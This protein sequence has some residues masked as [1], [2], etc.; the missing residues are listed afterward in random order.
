MAWVVIANLKGV[1]GDAAALEILAVT[2][3]YQGSLPDG[4]NMNSYN[5]IGQRGTWRIVPGW[6]YANAPWGSGPAPEAGILEVLPPDFDSTTAQHVTT[7]TYDSWRTIDVVNQVSGS[8]KS[9]VAH[10]ELSMLSASEAI[11][12][13]AKADGWAA[14]YDPTNPATRQVNPDTGNIQRILDGLGNHPDAIAN[15]N[16]T[17]VP[18]AFGQLWGY[19]DSSLKV[20]FPT[21]VAQPVTYIGV[22]KTD[23]AYS[24]NTR[25]FI[26]GDTAGG[27]HR[28]YLEPQTSRLVVSDNTTYMSSAGA[29]VTDRPVVLSASFNGGVNSTSVNGQFGLC[30]TNGQTG[31]PVKDVRFGVR[32]AGVLHYWQGTIGPIL[33]YMGEIPQDK[34]ARMSNLL[35]SLAG[36]QRDSPPVTEGARLFSMDA[37]GNEEFVQGDPDAILT[38]GILSMTKMIN[39]L[40]AR[41][42]LTSNALLDQV[43]TL[44][45]GDF[46]TAFSTPLE[47]GDQITYRDLL[48]L[49][50]LP[51]DNSAPVALARHIGMDYITGDKSPRQ[52]Y[53][54]AMN[55]IL[56]QDLGFT[57]A[58]VMYEG[59]TAFLSPRQVAAVL[60]KLSEDP[61][62][63]E[64]FGKF[65]YTVTI[66]GANARTFGITSTLD[67]VNWPILGYVCG[68]SGT[69]GGNY[70]AAAMWKD[71]NGADHFTVA[72]DIPFGESVNAR[73]RDIRVA[74]D[75][76]LSG[77]KHLSREAHASTGTPIQTTLLRDISKLV[78]G[79]ESGVYLQRIGTTVELNFQNVVL[80]ESQWSNLLPDGFR[81]ALGFAYG[82]L[83]NAD[84]TVTVS[85][86]RSSGTVTILDAI[87]SE[88]YRGTIRFEVSPSG[89]WPVV[90][91][92]GEYATG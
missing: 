90:P 57:G 25:W 49:M 67:N 69:G 55:D 9:S 45:T 80:T 91:Y 44:E 50:A 5:R 4:A 32:S 66:T 43:V 62:L 92:P 18:N 26:G 63:R 75:L 12:A 79:G 38:N 41:K 8:W 39:A 87:T 7:E 89:A 60:K 85:V 74:H 84:G 42:Y 83:K 2:P 81:P 68:K 65:S 73:Y 17:T 48:H 86:A 46:N 22:G 70:H 36:I 14:V 16:P 76:I 52:R 64:I 28:V 6:T 23:D 53:V 37:K 11:L 47:V 77:V 78:T 72:M 19:R 54:D 29:V 20:T 31:G 88:P 56:A 27:Q 10:A 35:M 82:D 58:S 15:T 51:S 30:S 40:A 13:L 61:V 34:L 1:P 59:G 3:K 24:S 71:P 33:F 21:A